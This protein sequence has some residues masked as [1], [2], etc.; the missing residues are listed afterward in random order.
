MSLT[1]GIAIAMTASSETAADG[2]VVTPAVAT[3]DALAVPL[4]IFDSGAA[5]GAN[6]ADIPLSG[7]TDASDG[8][9]IE[10]RIV[11]ADTLAE[12]HPWT[13]I[14][15]AAGGSWS[16][17]YPLVT[18][19]AHRLRAEVRV[20]GS[21][22][23]ATVAGEI[24]VGHVALLIG[25]S[26]D[27]RMF[28][29]G[30][31]NRSYQTI[32]TFADASAED[33]VFVLT[34]KDGAGSYAGNGIQPVNATTPVTASLAHLANVFTRNA[35]GE[36]LLLIDA[37]VSGTNRADLVSD[38][39]PDRD[40]DTTLGDGVALVR[41]YGGEVGV[42][43]D[44]WTAA[45]GG[46]VTFKPNEFPF[47]SG[48]TD[49]GAVETYGAPTT[50]EGYVLDHSLWDLSGLN[51]PQALFD[52]AVTRQAFHGPHRF[53]DYTVDGTGAYVL[54]LR[55]AKE[56]TRE[57]IRAMVADPLLAP[58]MRPKG[59]EI[60]LYRNGTPT[61]AAW[62][63][64]TY[65]KVFDPDPATW[66]AWTDFSHPSDYSDDGLTGRARHTAVAALYAL[67]LVPHEVPVLNRADWQTTHVDLWWEDSQ[68]ATPDISTT[69]RERAETPATVQGHSYPSDVAGFHIDGVPATNVQIVT[70]LGH[71]VLP[72]GIDIIRVFPNAGTF[73]GGSRVDFG[74]GGASGVTTAP[75][76]E[77]VDVWKNLPLVPAAAMGLTPAAGFDGIAIEP[78]P[79]QSDIA[80]TLASSD[81]AFSVDGTVSFKSP[82]DFPAATSQIT[83]VYDIV[84][85]GDGTDH[86]LDGIEGNRLPFHIQSVG[87][88]RC[89]QVRG[90][91]GQQPLADDMTGVPVT[92]G[93]RTRLV[94]A[95]DLAAGTA[96]LWKDDVLV[97]DTTF[98][99]GTT[100]ETNRGF[101]FMWSAD[102][103]RGN[104]HELAAY[105]ALSSDGTT[106]GLGTPFW[107]VLGQASAPFYVESGTSFAATGTWL[108]TGTPGAPI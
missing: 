81:P 93:A 87:S 86:D 40:W 62:D 70:T 96:R 47:Y 79:L 22:A 16:G 42:V 97:V 77:Y 43:L 12:V 90:V 34:F 29:G 50:A 54:G 35:A 56:G 59:P 33:S 95:V 9:Q 101:Q 68:G 37:T 11:R 108:L 45:D 4:A 32:P 99:G 48:L 41:S 23:V 105:Y 102:P 100:L 52:A 98:A 92:F 84:P 72:D 24:M 58:I 27:A 18:R 15:T 103:L 14:A 1:I 85:T 57:A 21:T 71:P 51:R 8:E 104:V 39:D 91:A 44:S 60:L 88:L 3:P 66:V 73:D 10:A 53:E 94:L 36:K 61:T 78:M 17:A 2:T 80:S 6:A 26:E 63:G 31:D 82:T 89:V 49:T 69:W 7:T 5:R 74:L 76:D 107:Q 55:D 25:Q 13:A 38:A 83:L 75:Q 64:T 67:G 19:A 65:P 20:A 28:D 46:G 106:A 30:F